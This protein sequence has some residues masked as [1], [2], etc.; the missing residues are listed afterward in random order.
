MQRNI[1]FLTIFAMFLTSAWSEQTNIRS[2][3]MLVENI[4]LVHPSIDAQ[5]S[6]VQVSKTAVESAH[7]QYFPT[8]SIATELAKSR[9]SDISYGRGSNSVTTLRLQQP[10]WT[11]GRLTA[12]VTKAEAGVIVTSA[13]FESVRQDLA[14]RTVQIYSDWYGAYLKG[15]SFQKSLDVHVILRNQINRRI[16]EG[17]SAASDLTLLVG[18]EQQT[19]ADLSA[20]K[21]QQIN[22]IARL[23]QLAGHQIT[24]QELIASIVPAMP[25]N[26][27]LTQ[28]IEQAKQEN[29]SV[30]RAVA[31]SKIYDAEI[32]ERKADLSPELYARLERQYGNFSDKNSA[33]QNRIFIGLQTKFGAG[34]S[35]LSTIDGA[36][37]R[38]LA[39]LADVEST[40]VGLGEQIVADYSLAASGKE[41]LMLLSESLDSSESIQEAWGRQF[42]AGRKTWL[43]VMNAARELAQVEA[44]VAEVQASQTLLTWRIWIVVKGVDISLMEHSKLSTGAT[45]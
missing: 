3:P 30:T 26:E 5:R 42:L 16:S 31:Q 18:R 35:A 7:W 11:G 28:L 22:S 29:P 45:K 15:L 44:Q 14:L 41:R 34:F 17:I 4:L 32:A 37:A 2:L 38:Y 39:S 25:L 8:P 20:V 27:S 21:S 10:L 1:T 9:D 6:L 24:E 23:S 19:A 43:D 12:G 33:P 40:R 36:K 13:Q